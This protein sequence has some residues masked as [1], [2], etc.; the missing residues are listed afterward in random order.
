MTTLS[1]LINLGD[2]V[3]KAPEIFTEV[4]D[5]NS[6]ALIVMNQVRTNPPLLLGAAGWGWGWGWG[7]GACF[8]RCL[9]GC[10]PPYAY[11]LS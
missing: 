5:R 4:A 3:G 9:H 6:A 10:F 2:I 11:A 1:Q 7:W 8:W